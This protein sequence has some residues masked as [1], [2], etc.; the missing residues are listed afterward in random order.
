MEPPLR[1]Q[2]EQRYPVGRVL[3]QD[4][5]EAILQSIAE[6]APHVYGTDKSS[7]WYIRPNVPSSQFAEGHKIKGRGQRA[8]TEA[9]REVP[10][11]HHESAFSELT[12]AVHGLKIHSFPHN[13][14]FKT[15]VDLAVL[16]KPSTSYPQGYQLL[17]EQ[18]C[19]TSF[20]EV[21]DKI[22]QFILRKA[23][24]QATIPYLPIRLG[25][26]PLQISRPPVRI[27]P[28]ELQNAA[29]VTLGPIR[30]VLLS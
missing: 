19:I 3:S 2:R 27:A 9:L 30:P 28:E 12:L 24:E 10:G 26:L 4:S 22:G 7:L 17:G 14:E 29:N 23:G 13:G 25:F 20:A 8:A 1:L 5:L 15:A 6:C 16:D 18:A 11:L 21:N